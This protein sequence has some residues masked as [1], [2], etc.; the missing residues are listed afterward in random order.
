MNTIRVKGSSILM[1]TC[2]QI[3]KPDDVRKGFIML[4]R[5]HTPCTTLQASALSRHV[6][7]PARKRSLF[8]RLLETLALHRQ[9]QHLA[10]LDDAMLDDIGLTREAAQR[11]AQRPI[12]DAPGHWLR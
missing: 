5:P 1:G 8:A 4:A 9:R 7:H 3:T 11:E 12:W 2:P 10:Q 6:Q